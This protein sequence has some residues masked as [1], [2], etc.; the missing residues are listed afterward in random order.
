MSTKEKSAVF[1][2]LILVMAIV[3]SGFYYMVIKP[4]LEKSPAQSMVI[5][6][7]DI[8][9]FSVV[10]EAE[11]IWDYHS[12]SG[13]VD[14]C[15]NFLTDGIL[16]STIDIR[17]GSIL[18]VFE[19]TEGA[20]TEMDFIRDNTVAFYGAT[21]VAV[22]DRAYM[23]EPML[24]D[25][26]AHS[27]LYFSEGRVC[28]ELYVETAADTDLDWLSSITIDFG[29]LQVEKIDRYLNEPNE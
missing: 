21:E 20:V 29:L 12:G 24:F 10:D 4:E 15:V 17:I 3:I 2:S 14:C 9:N 7:V 8:P 27:F 1:I 25:D 28:C 22:G 23:R 18:M 16:N 5:R 11:Y 13:K 6:G 26:N 19:T